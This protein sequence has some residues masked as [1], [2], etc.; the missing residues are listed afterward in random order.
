MKILLIGLICLSSISAFAGEVKEL[1]GQPSLQINGV[2]SVQDLND[3]L[4]I[5]NRLDASVKIN[6]KIVGASSDRGLDVIVAQAAINEGLE[7]CQVIDT[8]KN[9]LLHKLYIKR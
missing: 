6:N 8:T 2:I 5:V 9:P 7:L 1:C 3:G 4:S